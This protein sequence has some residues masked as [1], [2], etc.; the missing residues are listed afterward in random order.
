MIPTDRAPNVIMNG[1]K[2]LTISFRK[3]KYK[4]S[5]CFIPQGLSSFPKIFGLKEMK[6]GFVFFKKF[7]NI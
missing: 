2:L 5:H 7:I 4:D 3:I 1:S 6:K